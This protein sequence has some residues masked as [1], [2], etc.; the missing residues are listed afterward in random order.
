MTQI[1]KQAPLPTLSLYNAIVPTLDRQLSNLEHILK[2]GEANALE[3]KIDPDV[4]LQARLAPD[5]A[6]L[7]RQVQIACSMAKN[8]LHRVVGT[9]PPV[10]EDTEQ[11]FEELYALIAKA[12]TEL[13]T[14]KRGDIDGKEGRAFSVPMAG[15]Q[16]DFT[17]MHYASGFV[18][19]NVF[20]HVTTA[21]NI[22]RHKGVPLGK[23]DF[24]GG[25]L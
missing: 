18:L 22:L 12:R 1:Q 9:T 14:F 3:R 15:T 20:F 11:S 10:Y 23:R 6:T 16:M 5:M 25:K 8:C 19:P 13:A 7:T 4:F 17:A 2:C 24:F 21:Y